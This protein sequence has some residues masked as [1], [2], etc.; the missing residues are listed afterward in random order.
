MVFV[1][2]G[3]R[4]GGRPRGV[5]VGRLA[6]GRGR[7]R[8][9]FRLVGAAA[10]LRLRI[11]VDVVV[12]SRCPLAESFLLLAGRLVAPRVGALVGP[13]IVYV[14]HASLGDLVVVAMK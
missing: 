10:V 13:E 8:L 1:D 7:S 14:L 6:L 12:A 3:P 9:T 2:R 11:D 4:A 5:V